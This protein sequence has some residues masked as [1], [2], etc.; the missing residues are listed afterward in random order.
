MV[1]SKLLRHEHGIMRFQGQSICHPDIEQSKLGVVFHTCWG[2]ARSTV[3]REHCAACG[4]SPHADRSRS[5]QS[6]LDAKTS[7]CCPPPW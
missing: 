1:T 5:R 4:Q 6:C 3:C 7:P 2:I